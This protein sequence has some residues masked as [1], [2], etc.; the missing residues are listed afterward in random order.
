MAKIFYCG[1]SSGRL[2]IL[3]AV[4]PFSD[5]KPLMSA[6]TFNYLGQSFPASNHDTSAH[7]VIEIVREEEAD[8]SWKVGFYLIEKAPAHFEESLRACC[9][10]TSR[11]I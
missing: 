6:E 8:A 10:A 4:M 11:S 1:G 3:R 2:G 9:K 5:L 7:T